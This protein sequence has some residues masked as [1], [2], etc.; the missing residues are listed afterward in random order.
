M[1]CSLV[2]VGPTF[3]HTISTAAELDALYRAPTRLVANKKTDRISPETARFIGRSRLVLIATSDA[4]GAVT[5]SPK[6]GPAGFVAVLDEH[7][8]AIPDLAG[9]NL[10][11]G[12]RNLVVNPSIGLLFVAA[13]TGETLR[14][15]GRGVITTDPN[16]IERV[17]RDVGRTPKV[18]IGVEVRRAFIHCSQSFDRAGLWDPATWTALERTEVM[19]V[20]RSHLADNDAGDALPAP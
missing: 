6:G 17:T 19:G 3:S 7:R 9:N 10:I 5:V 8:L 2:P 13:G 11:D 18:A 16:V 1:S 14:V 15:N 4:D 12:L 20:L